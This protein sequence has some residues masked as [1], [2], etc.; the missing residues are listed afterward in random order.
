MNIVDA[1]GWIEF[2]RGGPDAAFVA[3]P[4]QETERLIVPTATVLEVFAEVCRSH[5]EG[6]AL[7]AAAAMQQGT[8][9]ALDPSTALDAGRMCVQHGVPPGLGVVLAVAE[10]HDATVWTLDESIR[11]VPGVRYRARTGAGVPAGR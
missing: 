1:S 10:R 6:E 2:F 7:Q 4:L 5:G 8:V 3:E 11:Q 9:V